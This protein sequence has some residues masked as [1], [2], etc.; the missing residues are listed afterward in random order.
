MSVYPDARLVLLHRDPV[1]LCAS[2]CSLISTLSGT[3]SDADQ[4]AYIAQH[5]PAML[6]ESIRRIDAFRG[7]HPQHPIV[8]VHYAD[9]VTDPVGTVAAIYRSC[10]EELDDRARTSIGNY[11]DSHP[12]GKFGEHHYDVAEFGL[13]SAALAE[14]FAGY[15]RRYSVPTE[16]PTASKR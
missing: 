15:I 1:V 8:D 16:R 2:V 5:W 7:A 12:K 11:V 13:D 9:L 10:G 3:F 14:R 4:R 6:E